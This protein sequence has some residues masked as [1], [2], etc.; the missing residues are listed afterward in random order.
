VAGSIDKIE[1][2]YLTGSARVREHHGL[3]FDGNASFPFDLHVIKELV[4]ELPIGNHAGKLNQTVGQG[5]FTVID[6][7]NNAEISDLLH[8]QFGFLPP[9]RCSMKTASCCPA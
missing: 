2:E 5:G 7:G 8:A 1:P 4:T 6:M 9:A 3:A